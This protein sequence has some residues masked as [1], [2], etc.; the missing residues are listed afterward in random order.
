MAG[1]TFTKINGS[2][3]LTKLIDYLPDGEQQNITVPK[4]TFEERIQQ[5]N[6]KPKYITHTI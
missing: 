1:P 2:Q 3:I 6:F 4:N 5:P